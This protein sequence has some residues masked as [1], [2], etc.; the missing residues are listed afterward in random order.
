MPLTPR[1]RAQVFNTP[2]M[3]DG[4]RAV[5]MLGA[6]G[7][8]IAGAP[9]LLQGDDRQMGVLSG[10]LD[11]RVERGQMAA[12][13]NVEGVA[14]IEVEGT[15]VEKGAWIGMDCGETSYEG[16]RMQVERVRRDA[17]VKAVV[18]EV[19]SFGGQVSG[20][21]ETAAALRRLAAEKPMIA[22]LSSHA[23]SAAYLLASQAS[24]IV[25]PEFGFAGSIGA[26]TF[27]LDVSRQLDEAGVTVTVISSGAHKSDFTPVSPLPEDVAARAR[28]DL[29]SVR[30]RMAEVIG[31]ARG[32]RLD[33]AAA[34]ATE[35]ICLSGANAL[36]AGMVDALGD[37]HEAFAAFAQEIRKR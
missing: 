37:P 2:L 4:A 21:F 20:C 7:E 25:M 28:A 5:A 14:I 34:L 12:Y 6:V 22:I 3:I 32:K 10:R 26:I 8:R 36:K 24:R 30:A 17:S 29:D 11:R 1:L 18:L 27:H 15:L 33:A 31:A 35:A 19:D 23:C 13:P 16:L 9:L